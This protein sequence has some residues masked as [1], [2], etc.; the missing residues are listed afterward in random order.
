MKSEPGPDMTG[1]NT[2]A[3]IW[4][5]P[6]GDARAKGTHAWEVAGFATPLPLPAYFARDR[7]PK[8]PKPK[9][10][11]RTLLDI[12][13]GPAN[14]TPGQKLLFPGRGFLLALRPPNPPPCLAMAAPV[15]GCADYAGSIDLLVL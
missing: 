3:H 15:E 12:Q 9:L 6:G 13:R 14:I 1:R 2:A 4:Q 10:S 8:K 7:D 5:A 11:K